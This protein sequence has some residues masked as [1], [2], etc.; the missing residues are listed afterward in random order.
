M[1]V[2]CRPLD[3]VLVVRLGVTLERA[4]APDERQALDLLIVPPE[5]STACEESLQTNSPEQVVENSAELQSGEKETHRIRYEFG[6]RS[7]ERTI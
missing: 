6:P 5:L 1:G 4:G 3:H 2:G 7:G